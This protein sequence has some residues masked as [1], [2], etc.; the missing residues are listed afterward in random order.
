MT[1]SRW[2]QL[3]ESLS[4]S[5]RE[6]HLTTWNQQVNFISWDD[7]GLSVAVPNKF[8]RDWIQDHFIKQI[9]HAASE[10]VGT[11]IAVRID[12]DESIQTPPSPSKIDDTVEAAPAVEMPAPRGASTYTLNPRYA[13]DNFVVGPSNQFAHAACQAVAAA[14]AQNYNPLFLYGGVGLGKT[15]LLNAIGLEIR[16]KNPQMRITYISSEQFINKL[17]HSIRFDRMTQF[18]EMFRDS[19]DLLLI[20]DIQFI[21]GKERTQEEFFHTFDRLYNSQK[22]IVIS[23]DS[24]PND[25]PGL[26]ERLRSR[27]QWGLIA[28]IQIPDLETRV[29]IINKK[30]AAAGIN[31]ADDVAIFLASSIKSNIRELE[32][33]LIRLSAFASLLGQPISIEL[34]KE[35]LRTVLGDSGQNLS[36]DQIQKTVADFFQ[37]RLSDLLGKRRTRSLAFPRQIAMYLCRKHIDVSFPEIGQKFGGKD[38]STVVHACSKISTCIQQDASL[39]RQ[40]RQL[41]ERLNI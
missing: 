2:L 21:A 29:A 24:S 12:I 31:L 17:V 7:Q 35:V 41:E 30:A 38:H 6:V 28:D 37:I 18:R 14:P 20:D 39:Q 40:I 25:I 36:I 26:E 13:F 9:N 22:Q 1:D 33:S 19:S 15:H 16:R 34:A 11:D 27:F 8:I 5:L 23:S 32:G 3:N 10:L 4:K